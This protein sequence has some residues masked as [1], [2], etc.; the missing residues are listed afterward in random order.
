MSEVPPASQ[1]AAAPAPAPATAPASAPRTPGPLAAFQGRKPQAPAWFDVALAQ[2]P[3]RRFVEVQ[4]ARIETLVWGREGAPGVLLMHGNGAHA[5]WWSFIAPFLANEYRVV[6]LSWSGM[7]GSDWRDSYSSRLFVREAMT[8]AQATGLFDA[9]VKP[10][11]IGH[12]FG[13]FPTMAA[14][15][16]HGERL[17]A[18]V[19]FDTPLW[20]PEMRQKRRSPRD[21]NREF[22]PTRIYASQAEALER[23]RLMPEQPC[24]NDFIVD[25]IARTSLREVVA[26]NGPGYTWRFDPFLWSRYQEAESARDLAA[27][28]CP[29]SM[30]WGAESRLMPRAVVDYM[31]SLMPAGSP[32]VEVPHAGHHVMLD[33]PL[34]TV[35][36][37]RA[38][39]QR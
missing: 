20:T 23:F 39:L 1:S 38:L 3:E 2:L 14:A 9:A 8:V 18:I 5:D 15:A 11:F 17:R 35:A 22:K 37:F 24:E 7:G 36:V 10:V 31:R 21:P 19:L 12:S 4:G 34:A 28:R 16:D 32:C 6:A 27:V 13:G 26:D 29:V 30:V 33:Q 25:H